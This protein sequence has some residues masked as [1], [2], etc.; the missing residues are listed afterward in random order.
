MGGAYC[1]EHVKNSPGYKIA[2]LIKHAD[3]QQTPIEEAYINHLVILGVPKEEIVS[4]SLE[5]NEHGKCPAALIKSYL[6]GLL[7]GLKHIGVT[8]L[9]VADSTYFK[10]LTGSRKSE[11]HHG[12]ILKCKIPGYEY[13][14]VIL[15]VNYK[16]L[17]YKPA[18]QTKIVLSLNTLAAHRQGTHTNLGVGII[19]S[20]YYPK[21]ESEIL[22]A[23]ESLHQYPAITCDIETFSL[24]L[25]RARIGTIA[26][27]W[28]KHNGLAFPVRLDFPIDPN[29][30][31]PSW[32]HSILRI[33]F[34]NYKG[35]IIYHNG[36][37]DI[38]IL[39]YELF[40]KDP[41]DQVGLLRGLDI[42]YRN[43]DDTK[44]ITYL[45]TNNT[46]GNNLK[47]KA[48]AFEFAGNWANDDITDIT[49]IPKPELLRYNL[50]DCLATW[51]LREKNYPIMI[52]DQQEQIYKEIFL[53]TMK[54]ITQMEL[55]GMPLDMSAVSDVEFE[56]ETSKLIYQ[57][58]LIQSPLIWQFEK[59]L[60]MEA[61]IARNAKL[62]KKVT[63]ERDYVNTT[64]NPASNKQTRDLLYHEFGF[65]VQDLTDTGLPSVGGSTMKKLLNKLISEHNITEEE[66]K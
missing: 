66:L 36:N 52:Q 10:T 41:L 48:N 38:K 32:I 55:T 1:I 44:I 28:D 3:L 45:A 50:V 11:P 34:C 53:P 40:M 7:K 15:S 26:F 17:F 13:M 61:M 59:Y 29:C 21:T 51:Y 63:Y 25:D 49:K 23:I 27:A 2:I 20:E 6:Q 31:L 37:F 16:A 47:L 42:M 19:H 43:I 33:F 62:K 5:Y 54:V 12:Y 35:K 58:V 14:D 18:L 8:T 24:E 64:Y 9:L 57:E 30:P 65:E 56:L 39:I 46:S 22:E 4:F 60:R